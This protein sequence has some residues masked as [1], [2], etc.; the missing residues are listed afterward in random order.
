MADRSNS[1]IWAKVD[2]I[3]AEA[4]WAYRNQMRK[5][6]VDYITEHIKEQT[7]PQWPA[8][9]PDALTIGFARRFATYK[10]APLLF[11]DL[12]RVVQL[13]ANVDRPIQLVYS[14]KAHPH[15]KFGQQFI[16]QI[17]ELTQHPLLKGKLVFL[18]NYNMEIGRMLTSGSD[19]WLNNPRRPYEASGTSGQKVAIHAGLNLSI[20]DGWWPEGYDGANGWPIGHDASSQYK[21]P[22]IQDPEDAN[23]LYEALEN[24]VIPRF[25][26]R[27]ADG[28]PQG[29][30][31]Y[32]RNALRDLPYQFSGHRMV[33]D[34]IA[35]FYKGVAAIANA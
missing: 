24:E 33:S 26:N 9:D 23:F 8:L 14:G 22:A 18:E 7:M 12:D 16:H 13:F 35:Q 28:I 32:M 21:D 1:D 17:F 25:Y 11:T 2:D 15:D 30:V 31:E 34:Y 5:A 6:L 3:P 4:L 20:L 19:I 27:D 29:W 10:R